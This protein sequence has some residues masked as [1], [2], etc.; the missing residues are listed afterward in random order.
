MTVS[1]AAALPSSPSGALHA[2]ECF[3]ASRR[4]GA[5]PLA[6]SEFEVR[7]HALVQAV[8]R[9]AVAEEL[10]RLD[11]VAPVVRVDGIPHRFALRSAAPYMT[12]AGEVTVE[13]SLYAPTA[14]GERTVCPMELRAGIVEGWW[15][16]NA[17]SLA[18]WLTAHLTPGEVEEAL[19]RLGSMRPSRCSLDR[20]PKAVNARWEA[21]RAA[22]QEEMIQATQIPANAVSAAVS[23]D[24]VLTPMRDGERAAKREESRKAGKETRGPAGY[25]EVGCGSISYYDSDGERLSTIR[26][27]RMPE[28]GKATLKE[29]LR[30]EVESVVRRRSDLE[31]VRVADGAP[32]NWTFLSKLCGRGPEVLDFFHAAEHLAAAINDAL[33]EGTPQSK[34]WY[35]RHRKNLLE[36]P[37]GVDSVIRGLVYLLARH[38]KSLPIRRTIKFFRR[39]RARMRYADLKARHLPIGS[40]VIEATCKTLVSQRLK[41]SGMRWRHDGGQAILS[42]RAAVQSARFD[43]AW[44]LLAATYRTPVEDVSNVVALRRPACSG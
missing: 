37:T 17:A 20:L 33:G 5:E 27:G 30:S 12:M 39:N 2:L 41:R 21:D 40:G 7:L 23:L 22:I 25:Q 15:T 16:P 6:F 18:I 4:H 35:E 38:P 9:E 14:R 24:G 44:S 28:R 32:D 31:I 1:H 43:H 10:Q 34:A 26:L 19:G 8:E 29:L 11:T 13:R 36:S 3:I 42:F